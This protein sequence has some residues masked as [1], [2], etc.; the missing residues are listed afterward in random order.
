MKRFSGL[1]AMLAFALVPF[2]VVRLAAQAQPLSETV[3][4]AFHDNRMLIQCRIDGQGPF[5]LILD[6]GSPSFAVTPEVA[7][8]LGL[9]TRENGV[10][11]GAGNG[12]SQLRAAKLDSIAF[13]SLTMRHVDTD[14][15]D[16]TTIRTQFHFPHL[17]GI[18]G[19]PLLSRYVTFVN[20]DKGTITFSDSAPPEPADATTT[21]FDGVLP[22]VAA[23]IDG[24]PTTVL[25]DTGDRSSLTLFTPFAKQHAFYGK[26][27]S[28]S[29]VVT[30]YGVGGPVYADV[31]SLPHLDVLGTAFR[32]V[33]ARASRLTGG[34]FAST[35]QGGSIGTGILKRFNIVYDYGRKTIV[36]WPSKL[37]G[38]PFR[39]VPPGS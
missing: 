14:V 24:I 4:F 32:D 29:N 5:W 6:T 25:V 12:S 17:D 26:Y 22:I 13:G 2:S 34:A 38:E 16:L 21:P 23:R 20:V 30:G 3:P 39:F 9:A 35:D 31:F 37:F 19:Y 28:Q 1:A 10:A 36:A 7:A 18:A 33:V 27:P 11:T 15:I 8:R